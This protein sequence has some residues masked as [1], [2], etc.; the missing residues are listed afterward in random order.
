MEQSEAFMPRYFFTLTDGE[1][2]CH[3]FEGEVLPDDGAAREH[4]VDD[5]RHLLRDCVADI[6]AD[7]GW[8]VEITDETGYVLFV[9]PFARVGQKEEV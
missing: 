7:D 1:R 6:A 2:I 9:I 5:A 8:R 3:D 4:A